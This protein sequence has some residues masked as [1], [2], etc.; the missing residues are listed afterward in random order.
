MIYHKKK[1]GIAKKFAMLF[2][3]SEEE[4]TSDMTEEKRPSCVRRSSNFGQYSSKKALLCPKNP[5]LRTIQQQKGLPV[6]EEAQTSDTTGE[7]RP[8]SV[9]RSS[10]FGHAS[11]KKAFLCPKKLELRTRKGK[12]GLPVSEEAQTSDTAAAK[13]PPCVRRIPNFGQYSSKKAFQ[14]PKKP[15]LRTIQQQKGPPMSEEAQTSD[16]PAAKKPF[17]VRRIPN[18]G[19]GSSKKAFQCPKNPELRTRQRQKSLPV[20]EEAQTSDTPAAKRPSCVRSSSNFGHA[21]SKKASQ[22]PKQPELR[23]RQQQKGLPVSE[24]ARTS[25][26]PAAKRPPSVRRLPAS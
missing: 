20:S 13:R 26:T 24:E 4:R 17:C 23:T 18:F 2:L 19:H 16:T 15:K 5:E 9:R 3:V 14:C 6:S 12:K 11:R 25:D 8:S 22:C 10:N 7:K 21:S 1:H